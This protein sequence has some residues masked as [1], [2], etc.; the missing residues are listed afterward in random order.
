MFHTGY[1]SSE[2]K[3]SPKVPQKKSVISSIDAVKTEDIP[4]L[5]HNADKMS[6]LLRKGLWSGGYINLDAVSSLKI[7]LVRGTAL[8]GTCRIDAVVDGKETVQ[9]ALCASTTPDSSFSESKEMFL[10]WNLIF[11]G[12]LPVFRLPEIDCFCLITK[13]TLKRVDIDVDVYQPPVPPATSKRVESSKEKPRV[14]KYGSGRTT[15]QTRIKLEERVRVAD[16]QTIRTTPNVLKGPFLKDRKSPTPTYTDGF[17]ICDDDD[18]EEDEEKDEDLE[19]AAIAIYNEVQESIINKARTKNVVYKAE[20]VNGVRYLQP[21]TITSKSRVYVFYKLSYDEELTQMYHD[22]PFTLDSLDPS[23][24]DITA[25]FVLLMDYMGFSA[26]PRIL[27][28]R[29]SD[30]T[31]LGK[32]LV[33]QSVVRKRYTDRRHKIHK[34]LLTLCEPRFDLLSRFLE[35]SNMA[36]IKNWRKIT[37]KYAMKVVRRIDERLMSDVNEVIG[38]LYALLSFYW[39][40]KH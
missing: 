4:G 40:D 6:H 11:S 30:Q 39:S 14:P 21:Y 18:S 29:Q 24:K 12:L 27:Q 9:Y 34:G 37:D 13:E 8:S 2:M 3:K 25:R 5:G 33:T 23:E 38:K 19:N 28:W 31:Q 10:K 32:Q 35:I 16:R 36:D 17:N 15:I 1:K 7:T 26:S 20:V 22:T